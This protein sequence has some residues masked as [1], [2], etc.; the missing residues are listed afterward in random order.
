MIG[1]VARVVQ[2]VDA[3]S[4]AAMGR[5]A[6]ARGIR[7]IP[8]TTSASVDADG[9][10]VVSLCLVLRPSEALAL[11]GRGDEDRGDGTEH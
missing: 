1:L 3:W 7:P 8:V 9:N 10:V 2:T 11:V 6:A 5:L 4:Q